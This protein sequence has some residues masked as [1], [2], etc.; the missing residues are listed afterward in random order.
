MDAAAGNCKVEECRRVSQNS[1]TPTVTKE[2][3]IGLYD[4]A[5]ADLKRLRN[6]WSAGALRERL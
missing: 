5:E 4:P 2:I 3:Q 6:S 1:P